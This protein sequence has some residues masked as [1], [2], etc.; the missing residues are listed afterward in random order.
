M[1]QWHS[2][3]ILRKYCIKPCI[4]KNNAITVITYNYPFVLISPQ[5]GLLRRYEQILSLYSWHTTEQNIT[6]KVA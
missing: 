3:K 6:L 1:L 2:N 5:I 4:K